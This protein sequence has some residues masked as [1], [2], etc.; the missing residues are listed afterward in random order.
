MCGS[1]TASAAISAALLSSTA[2]TAAIID[3]S[4]NLNAVAAFECC[5]LCEKANKLQLLFVHVF[6]ATLCNVLLIYAK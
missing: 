5:V 1:C 6:T 4:D 2:V 3:C